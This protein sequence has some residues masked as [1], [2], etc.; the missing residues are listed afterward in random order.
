MLFISTIK[1]I[2]GP[3]FLFLCETWRCWRLWLHANERFSMLFRRGQRDVDCSAPQEISIYLSFFYRGF[4]P[5]HDKR[6]RGWIIAR[7][8]I[9]DVISRV[10]SRQVWVLERMEIFWFGVQNGRSR[11][12]LSDT[13]T[14]SIRSASER[15]KILRSRYV[16]KP[17]KKILLVSHGDWQTC[18]PTDSMANF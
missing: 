14:L 10:R 11:C 2:T 12:H 13:S 16:M 17:H 7:H 15:K 6:I 3:S 18:A 9:G 5:P 1:S 4:F 8:P